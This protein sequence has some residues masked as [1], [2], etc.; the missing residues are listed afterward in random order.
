MARVSKAAD[1]RAAVAAEPVRTQV[2][3]TSLYSTKQTI[4]P[5]ASPV[6]KDLIPGVTSGARSRPRS[7]DWNG[8]DVTMPATAA[9]RKSAATIPSPPARCNQEARTRR[10]FQIWF[11]VRFRVITSTRVA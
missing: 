1:T 7:R 4:Q 11:T 5:M 2:D 6:K 10:M 9:N 3:G 8:P